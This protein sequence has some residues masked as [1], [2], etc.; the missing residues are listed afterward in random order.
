MWMQGAQSK[1]NGTSMLAKESAYHAQEHVKIPVQ[2]VRGSAA[3]GV[4]VL[5]VLCLMKRTIDAFIHEPVQGNVSDGFL[6]SL[7]II[8]MTWFGYYIGDHG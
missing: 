1:V 8:R 3:M 5:M 6:Y 7:S 4:A 2:F